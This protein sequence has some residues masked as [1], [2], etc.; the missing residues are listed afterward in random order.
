M[1]AMTPNMGLTNSGLGISRW[2]NWRAPPRRQREIRLVSGSPPLRPNSPTAIA[3]FTRSAVPRGSRRPVART[4]P[5]PAQRTSKKTSVTEPVG[6]GTRARFAD[7]DESLTASATSQLSFP[8]ASEIQHQ[9]RPR[10][11]PRLREALE[12]G[13]AAVEFAHVLPIPL[14]TAADVG[15]MS[16]PALA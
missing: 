8:P 7:T 1:R 6:S 16:A 5:P 15:E 4:A 3:P 10:I 12:V 14:L 13:A 9:R 11:H 2:P